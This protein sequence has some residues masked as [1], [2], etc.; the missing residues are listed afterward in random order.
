MKNPLL[1]L[2]F[3]LITF[4]PALA[5]EELA[6]YRQAKQMIA[7]GNFGQA[8]DLL[9]PFLDYDKY[10]EVANYASYHYARAAYGSKQYN[11]AQ[12][13]LKQLIRARDFEHNDDAR[14]LLALSNFQQQNISDALTEIQGIQAEGVREEAYRASYEFLQHVSSSV[15]IVNLPNYKNNKGLVMALRNQLAKRTVLSAGEQEVYNSIKDLDFSTEDEST[16]AY[17]RVVNQTLEVAVMLPFN[18]TGGSGVKR[19]DANNFVFE[20]FQGINFAAVEAKEQGVSLIIRTFDTERKPGVVQKILEDPFFR[21][22]DVIIGPIYPE[23]SDI[24]SKF[25]EQ[26][27]IPFVNP[28]SNIDDGGKDF[29]YSYLFRP[30]VETLSEGIL[31]YNSRLPGKKIAI[32]YSGTSRDEKLASLYSESATK[33]GY[34]I[35]ANRKVIGRD[36]RDFFDNLSVGAGGGSRVDQIVIFSDDPNIASPTFAVMESLSTN[37]PILV[38]DSWLYFNFA[39][40]EMLDIQNFH[41]VGNNTVNVTKEEIAEFRERFFKSYNV[42]PGFNAHLGYEIIYWITHVVNKERGFDFQKNLNQLAFQDGKLTFGFD[43]RNS[44]SNNFV[45]ILRLSKGELEVE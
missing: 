15:L 30:S 3:V 19:L 31:R 12:N 41:F 9:S 23:E 42:Y 1:L 33:K 35:V 7:T 27:K 14:Y 16:P 38:L 36:M 11:L 45:P 29:K 10:G 21:M 43:F 18:Y 8:M 13:A 24:V 32:A 22:A 17:E 28:L 44:N 39:S 5:Q 20:L 4:R 26:R 6:E 40:Y 37:V 25:A 34:Q 2:L